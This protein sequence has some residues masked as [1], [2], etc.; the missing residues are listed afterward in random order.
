MAL[1][2]HYLTIMAMLLHILQSYLMLPAI[3]EEVTHFDAT[4]GE[5][6]VTDLQ[7]A[8]QAAHMRQHC[9]DQ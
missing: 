9:I 5:G 4:C 1:S 8:A 3:Q 6:V 7:G 2:I